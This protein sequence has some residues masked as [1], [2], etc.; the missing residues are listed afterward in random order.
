M[1]C[2]ALVQAAA[3]GQTDSSAQRGRI[4]LV[5]QEVG[6]DLASSL[7]LTAAAG[8]LVNSVDPAGPAAG[9]GIKAGDVIL[10]FND[11]LIDKSSELPRLVAETRPG[12][13]VALEIYR[14]R[15]HRYVFVILGAA[16]AASNREPPAASVPQGHLT[17]RDSEGVDWV[18]VGAIQDSRPHGK[19]VM[20]WRTGVRYEGDFVNGLRTGRGKQEWPGLGRYEGDFVAGVRT[21]KGVFTWPSG[22]R[23]EGEFVDGKRTEKGSLV[24]PAGRQAAETQ[25]VLL[26]GFVDSSRA[27]N[28]S[29][30]DPAL[31]ALASQYPVHLILQDAVYTNPR[32]DITTSVVEFQKSRKVQPSPIKASG[33]SL[34]VGVVEVRRL[35]AEGG[36]EQAL[37]ALN[38][39]V[40]RLAERFDLDLVLQN[41]AFADPTLDITDDLLRLHRSQA[42]DES[43]LRRLPGVGASFAFV[44]V[45][46]ILRDSALA[47]AG[48]RR[49]EDEFKSRD[50]AKERQAFVRR[51]D[52]EIQR[53]VD[54][55]TRVIRSLAERRNIDYVLQDVVYAH[56][57]LDITLDVIRELDAR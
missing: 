47:K 18:Y 44:A 32:L 36:G 48:E 3:Y 19:G 30:Q 35:I 5:I 26:V 42:I 20:T 1:L 39:S 57:R 10:R 13:R 50:I 2:A 12:T 52:E 17:G 6:P 46:R 54:A 28:L 22:A 37:P 53:V 21:G 33:G 24:M 15:K 38:Q 55:G 25:G 23:F 8:A 49:L 34:R 40:K 9:S 11:K 51:R 7:G 41:A 14:E 27:G 29:G 16:P 31:R 43:R 4:G 45:D 56:P